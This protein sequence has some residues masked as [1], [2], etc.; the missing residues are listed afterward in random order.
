VCSCAP[1]GSSGPIETEFATTDQST[2][3]FIFQLFQLSSSSQES[4][5]VG[6]LQRSAA[7]ALE[8]PSSLTNYV[9]SISKGTSRVQYFIKAYSQLGGG[10]NGDIYYESPVLGESVVFNGPSTALWYTMRMSAASQQTPILLSST[11]WTNLLFEVNTACPNCLQKS[12]SSAFQL[13]QSSSSI[14]AAM[15]VLLISSGNSQLDPQVVSTPPVG[16]AYSYPVLLNLQNTVAIQQGSLENFQVLFFDPMHSDQLLNPSGWGVEYPS[17]TSETAIPNPT[18]LSVLPWTFDF[19]HSP[20]IENIYT[21]VSTAT[22][23]ATATFIMQVSY[24][25]EPPVVT[26]PAL[27][28]QANHELQINLTPYATDPRG[29]TV[30]FTLLSA[31][32]GMTLTSNVL[33]WNPTMAQVGTASLQV[34]ATNTDGDSTVVTGP[35]TI[36]ADHYPSFAPGTA[37]TWALNEGTSGNFTFTANDLDSDPVEVTCTSG[38]TSLIAGSPTTAG[39]PVTTYPN[40]SIY[41]L[42]GTSESVAIPFTPSYLQTVGADTT[43]PIVLSINYPVSVTTLRQ[44]STP[45]TLNVTLDIHNIADPPVWTVEPLPSPSASATEN[46]AMS[47]M[48]AATATDPPYNPGTKAITYSVN[49]LSSSQGTPATNC[50]WVTVSASG[51]IGGTPFYQSAGSCTVSLRASDS[52]PPAT[53]SPTV[54]YADSSPVTIY[55]VDVPRPFGSPSPIPSQ[56]ATEGVTY[57]LNLANYINDPD[58]TV[59][60]PRDTDSCTCVNCASL[61]PPIAANFNGGTTLSWIPSYGTAPL[62][63]TATYTGIQ[64]QCTKTGGYTT[65]ETFNLTLAYAPAPF[66]IGFV[67]NTLAVTSNAT[68]LTANSSGSVTIQLS[69]QTGDNSSYNYNVTETCSP[70]CSVSMATLST[71]AGGPSPTNLTMTLAPTYSDGYGGGSNSSL[72]H[73][74][75]VTVTDAAQSTVT[76]SA[77][78]NVAVNTVDRALTA[79]SMNS[80]TG[81]SSYAVSIDGSNSAQTQVALAAIGPDSSNDTFTYSL[82]SGT[83]GTIGGGTWAFSPLASGCPTGNSS[84]TKNVTI[85]ATSSHGQTISRN[86]T[87]TISN[88][89][90][91]SGGSCPY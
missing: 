44:V 60:D 21:N 52:L 87:I 11:I 3:N 83:V 31:P 45:P 7:G 81:T 57:S 70:N 16:V 71:A 15:N 12:A 18:T 85:L 13:V 40:S 42:N 91:G 35:I 23:N 73:S 30:S 66:V 33:D 36:I 84:V 10:A 34:Q 53:P 56:S 39:W 28:F 59:G 27:T 90:V 37:T 80:D 5:Y 8:L 69:R 67:G 46:I 63:G 72:A 20:G 41:T 55:V 26:L 1:K 58:E 32:T 4:A 47:P 17:A 88:T 29:E 50:S 75:T 77:V 82:S 2:A 89:S 19:S 86:M 76:A 78:L 38:C 6:T 48:P 24:S 62:N 9:N 74:I 54:L 49:Y 14:I 79:L 51:Q 22:Q 64:V 68:S 65:T 25:A 43:V 61:T